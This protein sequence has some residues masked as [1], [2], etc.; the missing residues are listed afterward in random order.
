MSS[1]TPGS[2]SLITPTYRGDYERS[3]L[4]FE[5]VDRFVTSFERHYVIVHDEDLALF[6]RFHGGRR[7]VMRASELLPTWLHEIPLLRWRRR[8][9][10]WSFRA[11][12]VRGWHTQQ[13]VKIKAAA[14]LPE[15]RYC[16]IDSDNAFFRPFDV[17]TL[18]P[19]QPVILRVDHG[20]VDD[21]HANHKT[22]TATACR[23]L[24]LPAPHFPADDFIDQIVIWDRRI[25]QAMIARIEA[26]T[27]RD[28]AEALCQARHFSEYMT[29]GCFVM[30]DET[31][32]N[33]AE[34]TTESF[35]CTHWDADPLSRDAI[36]RMLEKAPPRQVSL[37]IQSFNTTPIGDIRAALE[38]YHASGSRAAA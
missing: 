4:L 27:K 32:R 11:K 13:L 6:E 2:V 37:C 9:Y 30:G 31:L 28:W 34:I 17:S 15:D 23:V 19:P 3:V 21:D 29:Y 35:A 25:V 1:N 22:W 16:L 26:V 10:F 5:S 36:I 18:A 20:R 38:A 33:A 14:V 12:P 8:R 7:V 24:G